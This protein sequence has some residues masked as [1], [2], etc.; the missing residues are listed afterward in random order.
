MWSNLSLTAKGLILFC[1]P[2]VFEFGFVFMLTNYLNEAEAEAQRAIEASRISNLV[3]Q[4]TTDIYTLY[5]KV[6]TSAA[7]A[8]AVRERLDTSY[9]AVFDRVQLQ[10]EKLDA[11]TKDHPELNSNVRQSTKSI[12]EARAI[13]DEAMTQIRSGHIEEVLATHRV[14]SERLGQLLHGVLAN[15]LQIVARHEQ[16]FALNSNLKQQ[17]IRSRVAQ[18]A[19]GALVFNIVL[20]LFMA[21]FFFKTIVVRLKIMGENAAR[22]AS[23]KPLAPAQGGHDEIGELDLAFHQMAD[24]IIESARLKQEFVSMLTHDLRTPLTFIQGYLEMQKQGLLGEANERGHKLARLADR[25]SFHMMGLI[26]DLLDSQ[27]IESNMLTIE[28]EEVCVAEL[29]EQ[30]RLILEDW[31]AEH[32]IKFQIEDSDLFVRGDQEKLV[33]VLLNLVSNAV[34]YSKEGDSIALGATESGKFVEIT[35]A[36][37]GPGIPRDMLKSVF[38][39]FQQV[40]GDPQARKGSG[41]GLAICKQLVTIHGGKI[42]VSSERGQ[43]SV[44]HFTVP[45][46]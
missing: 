41:L 4:A 1:V 2:L 32:G 8:Y 20:V 46:V 38:E 25:N 29:F 44:F 23:D 11:L 30:V 6:S 37:Q 13:L 16:E 33:R 27:K 28:Q 10:Y 3:S 18:L 17:Q 7:T 34:K 45:S 9:Q 19:Y 35:V 43:G 22:L 24:T 40:G 5:K 42:W 31:V 21:L 36:D 26:N 15:D 12:A 14:K 39:R